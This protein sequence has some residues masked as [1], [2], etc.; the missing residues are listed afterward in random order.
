LD[1]A[2]PDLP[3]V[4]IPALAFDAHDLPALRTIAAALTGT[5]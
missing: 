1:R 3:V 5:A 4:E 2:H